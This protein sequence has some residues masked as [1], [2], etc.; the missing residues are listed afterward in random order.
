MFQFNEIAIDELIVHHIGSKSE[1]E[2]I[3]LSN[4]CINL[5]DDQLQVVLM[6]YFLTPFKPGEL[7][8]LAHPEQLDQNEV[9]ACVKQIFENRESFIEQSVNLANHLYEQSAH[10]KIKTG[11][12]YVAYFSNC[13][14]D[15]ETVEA[16]GLFKSESKETFL[17]VTDKKSTLSVNYDTGININKLDKGCL[18]FNLEPEKGYLA[19]IIDTVNKGEEARY[20]RDLFLQVKPRKDEFQQTRNYL[21]MCKTFVL[22]EAPKAF[23]ITKADQADFLNK[24]ATYFKKNED[25]A[26]DEFADQ[27]IKQPE[28]VDSFKNYKK[29]YESEHACEINDEFAI[30]APAVKKDAKVFKGVIKLDKNFHIYVHGNKE[31]IMKGFDESTG[32]HYYQLFFKEEE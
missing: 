29:Q 5:T 18:I 20:W 9:Y 26:F 10:P 31:Y 27:V 17:K 16:I 13:L 15:G 1:E 6:Q 14:F 3:K 7:F 19:A 12:F 24:S 28:V 11:E 25:F 8:H 32:M 23:E 21:D 4:S 30:S 2:G 22:E